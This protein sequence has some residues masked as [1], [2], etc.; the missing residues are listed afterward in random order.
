MSRLNQR[1]Y[2][3]VE[4]TRLT[5]SLNIPATHWASIKIFLNRAL[6][7]HACLQDEVIASEAAQYAILAQLY[8]PYYMSLVNILLQKVQYPSDKEYESWNSGTVLPFY[9]LI[10]KRKQEALI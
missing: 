10:F 7:L 3:L 6:C 1:E 2:S 4:H 5:R 9:F 8:I